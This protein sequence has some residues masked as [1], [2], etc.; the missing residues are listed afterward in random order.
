MCVQVLGRQPHLLCVYDCNVCVISRR[1]CFGAHLS[2]PWT[3]AII[4][5]PLLQCFLGS[6][7]SIAVPRLST[8]K[9][10]VLSIVTSYKSPLL[11]TKRILLRLK[12]RGSHWSITIENSLMPDPFSKTSG[13]SCLGPVTPSFYRLLTRITSHFEQM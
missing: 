10:L 7:G 11:T 1:Q 6:L 8:Q 4:L 12:V 5:S 2:M 13:C 3:L 9:S